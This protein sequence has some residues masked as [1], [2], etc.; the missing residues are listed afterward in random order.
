MGAV[1]VLR[2]NSGEMR[3]YHRLDL[4]LVELADTTVLKRRLIL[5]KIWLIPDFLIVKQRTR[6]GRFAASSE[7]WSWKKSR[8]TIREIQSVYF[9]TFLSWVS[10]GED[11]S[12]RQAG[13]QERRWAKGI[14][15]TLVAKEQKGKLGNGKNTKINQWTDSKKIHSKQQ[16]KTVNEDH[17]DTWILGHRTWMA[18]LSIYRIGP[19]IR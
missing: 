8:F 15:K 12:Y 5:I 4:L 2:S 11:M 6:I 16:S 18:V 7:R 17:L 10:M 13:R 9:A 1:R 19:N 14:P 3:N